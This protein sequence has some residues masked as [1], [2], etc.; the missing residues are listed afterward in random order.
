MTDGHAALSP[1]VD[2]AL[3][4]GPPSSTCSEPTFGPV[5]GTGHWPDRS[6]RLAFRPAVRGVTPLG[7][8]R[9]RHAPVQ[10]AGASGWDIPSQTREGTTSHSTRRAGS[11]DAHEP[12]GWDWDEAAA[13]AERRKH[14]SLICAGRA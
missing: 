10:T 1:T 13:D 6:T 9:P 14:P 8:D 5:R 7:Q 12:K 2:P 3:S 4:A 11:S